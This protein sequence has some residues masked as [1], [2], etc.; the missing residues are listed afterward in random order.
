V[1][2]HAYLNHHGIDSLQEL[3]KRPDCL[4]KYYFELD[5]HFKIFST[6]DIPRFSTRSQLMHYVCNIVVNDW[7]HWHL[8]NTLTWT[9]LR[10][11]EIYKLILRLPLKDAVDQIF[12]SSF[13]QQLIERNLPGG[14][15]L[16]SDQK[17]D[18][19]PM[20]NLVKFLDLP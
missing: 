8:G 4:H 16:I 6:T 5:K 19:A 10:D 1:T 20:K 18:L 14:T 2:A 7:Q 13:S 3:Q 11:L 15:K 9:P 17:N 12:N